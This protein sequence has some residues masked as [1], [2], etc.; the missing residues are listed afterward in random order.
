MS[1]FFLRLGVHMHC[2]FTCI[3]GFTSSFIFYM[4]LMY[5]GVFFVLSDA[6]WIQLVKS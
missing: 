1:F 5:V 6:S 4:K 3:K 2:F